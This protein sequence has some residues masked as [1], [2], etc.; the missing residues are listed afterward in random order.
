[1]R[2]NQAGQK[3]HENDTRPYMHTGG[4]NAH[5]IKDY[6][7]LRGPQFQNL[8]LYDMDQINMHQL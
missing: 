3:L 5:I 7:G 4:N 1:M 2:I 8:H 6:H